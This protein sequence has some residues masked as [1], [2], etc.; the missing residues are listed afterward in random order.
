MSRPSTSTETEGEQTARW[1][2]EFV[3]GL[4]LCPFAAS[5]FDEDR[6]RIVTSRAAD[7]HELLAEVL[8]EAATMAEDSETETSL[9][10]IPHLLEAFGDFL[11][12]IEAAEETLEQFGHAHR[13]QVVGFHPDYRFASSL[14]DDP[15]DYTNRSPYPTLHLL[16]RA[17]IARA[18]ATHPDPGSIPSNNVDRLRALGLREI[19]RLAGFYSPEDRGG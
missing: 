3:I 11:T 4:D 7:V 18:V 2:R 12:W 8:D 10:V 5:P 6:I 13:I 14:E 17:D 9:L 15:A 16:R 19:R 1:L